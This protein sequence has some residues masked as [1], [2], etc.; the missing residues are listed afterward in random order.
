MFID[1]NTQDNHSNNAYSNRVWSTLDLIIACALEGKKQADRMKELDSVIGGM[2][3]DGVTAADSISL[4]D[5]D[6]WRQEAHGLSCLL[7]LSAVVAM[8][9]EYVNEEDVANC[10]LVRNQRA[11]IL[12]SRAQRA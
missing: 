1:D 8:K 4:Q 6:L 2:L 3:A 5:F 12:D 9:G 7:E 10:F 11:R